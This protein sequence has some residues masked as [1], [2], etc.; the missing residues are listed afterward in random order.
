M[1]SSRKPGATRR[2]CARS[3][4]AGLRT[5]RLVADA[6][7][8]RQS[9]SAGG[10]GERR[11]GGQAPALPDGS[12]ELLRVYED[13]Q[14]A[15]KVLAKSRV[16]AQG[17]LPEAV[18]ASIQATFGADLSPEDVVRRIIDDVRERGDAALRH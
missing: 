4:R 2:C 3:G 14:E 7:P 6:I 15:R 12:R 9:S 8:R 1:F 11:G 17:A 16:A 13:A 5:G 18:K 10:E